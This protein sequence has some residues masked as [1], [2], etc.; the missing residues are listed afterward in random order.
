M[1]IAPYFTPY[2]GGQE[3]Y[4]YHLSRHLIRMGNEVDIITSNYPPNKETEEIDGI[5]VRRYYCVARPLR[6]PLSPGFLLLGKRFREYD[7]VHTHN[8]H[9][10]AAMVAAFFKDRYHAPLILTCHGQLRFGDYLSDTIE[11]WYSTSL[12]RLIFGKSDR[13]VALSDTDKQYISSFGIHEK[14]I[15]VIPNAIDPEQ[16]GHP[17]IDGAACEAVREKY[18]LAGKRIVLFV[19]QVIRRKGIE[20]LIKAIPRVLQHVRRSDVIFVLTGIGDYLFDARRDA[21]TMEIEENILFTGLISMEDLIALYKISDIFVLPSLS[22]GLP[23][24]ILEAMFFGLPVVGTDIP[25]V[26]DHFKD[27]ILLVPPRDDGAL[28]DAVIRLLEDEELA[29]RLS[30]D[31]RKLVMSKYVW[32]AVTENYIAMYKGLVRG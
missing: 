21:K 28:A 1:Q 25:G 16:L 32:N 19:G 24:C 18:S 22:E 7:I 9:S 6:N 5:N 27:H 12:G 14:K 3:R 20:Y 4:I 2:N 31:G 23:T 8:E 26:R 30:G 29:R 13:I 17:S 11:K 15:S 10:S